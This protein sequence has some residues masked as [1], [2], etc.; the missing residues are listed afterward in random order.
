MRLR[1]QKEV[2]TLQAVCLAGHQSQHLKER[3]EWPVGHEEEGLW[4]LLLGVMIIAF[5]ILIGVHITQVY[6]FIKTQQ[7]ST[8]VVW[9]SLDVNFTSKKEKRKQNSH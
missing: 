7:E 9:I 8:S 4:E 6:K 5:Y 1:F 2:L 3:L